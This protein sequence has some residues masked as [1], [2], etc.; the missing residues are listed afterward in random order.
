MKF[1]DKASLILFSFLVLVLSMIMCLLMIGWV[2]V[3]D[4]NWVLNWILQNSLASKI[5]IGVCIVL[6]LLAVK[7]IYFMPSSK[8]KKENDKGVLLENN[9]GKLL[10]TKETIE[11]IVNSVA[12]GFESTQNVKTDVIISEDN[13]LNI[14]AKLLVLPN[15][16]IKD[17]S[18]NL[19]SRIK[20]V[21]SN[22][23]GLN[24]EKV[25]I[26]VKNIAEEKEK[27]END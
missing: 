6:I 18:S 22:A 23:A 17:L 26:V 25:N 10:I 3:G 15:T 16:V 24:I 20:D 11:N 14:N 19:Q 5:T 7:C 1:L 8:N 21:V 13:K 2:S 9:D 27:Q 4:I 12:K